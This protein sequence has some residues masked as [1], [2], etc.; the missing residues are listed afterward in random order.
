M[1]P[2]SKVEPKIAEWFDV[3]FNNSAVGIIFL[4]GEGAIEDINPYG[5][6]LFGYKKQEILE[7]HIEVLIPSRFRHLHEKFRKEYSEE[8]QSRPMGEGLNLFALRKDGT[9]FP[10]EV[11]L[12]KKSYSGNEH[13]IAF[14][15]DITLRK[16]A[17]AEIEKLNND[18]EQTVMIRTKALREAMDQLNISNKRLEKALNFQQA[19][20][21]NAGAM[22]IA[23][24]EKGIIQMFNPEA[25]ALLG[26]EAKELIGKASPLIFHDK[27]EID[28][29]RKQFLKNFGIGFE[30]DFDV[31]T[32]NAK[33][34]VHGQEQ[35]TFIKKD[36]TRFPVTL[37]ITAL[38]NSSGKI[39]GYMG[40]A[41]D[42]KERQQIEE[43]LRESLKREKDLSELKSRFVSMA[44]HEFR[45]PLSTVL[46]SAY[47]IEKYVTRQDQPKRQKHLQ[48]IISAVTT[49]TDI[50]ND[51]LSLGR[52]EEGRLQVK[53]VEIN[54]RELVR[55][56]RSEIKPSMKTNQKINYRHTGPA[57][58][59]MDPNLMKHI[60][61]NLLSNAIKFSGENTQ[62]KLITGVYKNYLKLSVKDQG[63]GIPK[64]DQKHLME[65][66]FRGTNVTNVQGTGLGLNIVA[67]YAE[68]MNGTI[69]YTSELEKGTE[70]VIKF[71]N[72]RGCYE[73]DP[74][75]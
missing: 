9:E 29:K 57:Q 49:L 70:F 21:D 69:S 30:N 37:S 63:I 64:D 68:L 54:I 52:I 7:N 39:T 51:F 26:Y 13:V 73:K 28:N 23:T 19:L 38:R 56:I 16:K 12:G 17:M 61:L 31:L 55:E 5:L 62:I 44:S 72:N 42:V 40:V 74:A 35:F 59:C 41:I 24:D 11:S 48:R 22:I 1:L 32:E 75:N 34:N 67:K 50:L 45:T 58:V 65:R 3:L 27:K 43:T 20:L 46:S 66:F 60:I 14:V 47:L 53:S 10:V 33:R 8:P 15:I 71:H 6:K 2:P 4:D 18:L 36:G 25:A